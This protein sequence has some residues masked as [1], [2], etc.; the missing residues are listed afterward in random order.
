MSRVVGYVTAQNSWSGML[1]NYKL[2]VGG[3]LASVG[4]GRGEARVVGGDARFRAQPYAVPLP[5]M[6]QW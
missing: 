3:K 1:M 5:A 2:Y 6:Q 4:P